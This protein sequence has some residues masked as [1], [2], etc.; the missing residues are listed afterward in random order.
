MSAKESKKFQEQKKK[1]EEVSM[2][3]THART[4]ILAAFTFCAFSVEPS[5]SQS[6]VLLVSSHAHL[7]T[8]THAYFVITKC[9]VHR[10][11]PL[12]HHTNLCHLTERAPAHGRGSC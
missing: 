12:S 8:H 5:C 1:A 6:D 9:V 7:N 10:L 2:V 3:R 4:R 11:V